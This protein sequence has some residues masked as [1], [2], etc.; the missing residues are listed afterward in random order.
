ME[1]KLEDFSREE[2]MRLAE[3]PA[4]QQLI[5]MLRQQSSATLQQA[6]AQAQAGDYTQAAQAL[7]AMLSSPQ[8]QK[9]IKELG[10]T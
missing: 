9:L 2:V 6:L 10:G 3:S 4:G 5:A 8:A 7:R 1:K